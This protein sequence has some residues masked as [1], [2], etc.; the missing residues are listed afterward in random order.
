M[1]Y[2]EESGK[3]ESIRDLDA[4]GHGISLACMIFGTISLHCPSCLLEVRVQ[5]VIHIVEVIGFKVWYE[6][7]PHRS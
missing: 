2:S 3:V 7:C 1:D 5:A 6:L 4:D